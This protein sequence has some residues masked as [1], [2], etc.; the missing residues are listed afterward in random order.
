VVKAGQSGF[1]RSEEQDVRGRIDF[2]CVR[3][4][5]KREDTHIIMKMGGRSSS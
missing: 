1:E 4:R 5:K 3:I 2:S